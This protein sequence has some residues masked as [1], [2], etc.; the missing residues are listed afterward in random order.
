MHG[1]EKILQG[2]A[3]Q[4]Q[5]SGVEL[6]EGVAEVNHHQIAL[7]P[8]HRIER[9]RSKFFARGKH[10]GG[11]TRNL[12]LARCIQLAPLGPAEAEHLMQHTQA[13]KGKRHRWQFGGHTL[14]SGIAGSHC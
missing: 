1:L 6:V 10:G 5:F 14:Y 9:A 8:Q 13:L 3:V 7:V 4:L 11:L 2:G 12:R